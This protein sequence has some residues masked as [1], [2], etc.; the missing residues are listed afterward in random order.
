MR[1]TTF[2]RPL[3]CCVHLFCLVVLGIVCLQ[4]FAQDATPA[5]TT[6]KEAPVAAMSS[7][8]KELMLLAAKTNGLTGDDVQPWHLKANFTLLDDTGAVTDDGTFEEFWVSRHQ[9]KV[10]YKSKVLSLTDYGTG[11]GVLRAGAQKPECDLLDKTMREYVA[12]VNLAE[13]TIKNSKFDLQRRDMSGAQLLCLILKT[14]RGEP[15]QGL[16]GITYCLDTDLPI[17][18]IAVQPDDLRQ[19]VHNKVVKFQGRYIAGDLDVI[20]GRNVV[21]KAHLGQIEPLKSIHA[22]DF[23]PPQGMKLMPNVFILP[24]NAAKELLVNHPKPQYPPIA[25]AAHVFGTVVLQAHIGTDGRVSS[26]YVVSGPAMLQ[27]AALDAVWN[28]TYKP[29]YLDGKTSDVINIV[30]VTFPKSLTF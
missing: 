7:D 30:E 3:S 10:V 21:L 23:I 19:F 18:R 22:E 27:Q 4:S 1:K 29:Y 14:P 8:P 25:R 17:V 6:A 15:A 20:N 12:P 9:F 16:G 11:S 13:T 28:W 26:L 5:A 2:V 24:S